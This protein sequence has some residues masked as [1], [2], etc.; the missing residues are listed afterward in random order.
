MIRGPFGE[1]VTGT[2]AQQKAKNEGIQRLILRLKSAADSASNEARTH[3][4][5]TKGMALPS[6]RKNKRYDF[7]ALQSKRVRL[8]E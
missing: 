6:C 4:F 8:I 1:L 7:G 5:G 2:K 3:V